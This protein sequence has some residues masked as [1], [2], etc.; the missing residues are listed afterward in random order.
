[1]CLILTVHIVQQIVMAAGRN[2]EVMN[3][4]NKIKK[5]HLGGLQPPF[6]MVL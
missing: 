2:T 1:V 4:S 5:V 6:F 3:N